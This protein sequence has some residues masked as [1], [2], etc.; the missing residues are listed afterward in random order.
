MAQDSIKELLHVVFSFLELSPSF[1]A[2]GLALRDLII[3]VYKVWVYLSMTLNHKVIDRSMHC[4]P[5]SL[6][7]SPCPPRLLEPHCL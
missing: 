4:F 5:L 7:H 2:K 1:G 3:V 6:S